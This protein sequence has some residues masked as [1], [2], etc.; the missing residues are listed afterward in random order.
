MGRDKEIRKKIEG[1]RTMILEH[2]AKVAQEFLAPNPRHE[3]TAY[4][5]KRIHQVD[6]EILRLEEMLRRH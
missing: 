2:R 4:W 3:L 5:E 6:L 1:H